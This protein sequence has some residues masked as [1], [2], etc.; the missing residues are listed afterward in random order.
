[1]LRLLRSLS[2]FAPLGLLVVA[3]NYAGD[4]ARLFASGD[5]EAELAEQMLAGRPVVAS[6]R[7]DELRL[8]KRLAERREHAPDV[9]VL[10][11]SRAMPVGSEAFPGRT[12]VNASV[13]SASLEDGIALLELY[14]GLGLKPKLLVLAVE[15]WAL[16]GS[17]RNPSVALEPELRAGLRRLGV[18]AA[19]G[20]GEL[21]VAAAVS[22]KWLKLVSPAY[23]Q[24]SLLA[25]LTRGARAAGPSP[26]S[27][28]GVAAATPGNGHR[29]MPDGSLD[30]G[31]SMAGRTT[32]EAE[33][34]AVATAAG[35]PPYLQAPPAH[36]R[37]VL[38]SA[39]VKSAAERGIR[40]ALWLPPFHPAAYPPLVA[41]RSG[42]VLAEGENAVRALA[43][44]RQVPVLGS[45]DPARSGVT[46]SD[47][48]DYNH[49][50][51][52]AANQLMA[53][54]AGGLSP[55]VRATR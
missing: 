55:D 52:D 36:E 16:N 3:V 46:A 22:R 45:Y 40:V 21:P 20:Y 24:A 49:L 18:H 44:I 43:A 39:L 31:P 15:P 35:N 26:G 9:L 41:G 5:A 25:L 13:S 19:S 30:W 10:G 54:L 7:M 33:A 51:A 32:A 48:V 34:M 27:E 4:P 29:W 42:R 12:V 14:E 17:L 2:R 50:R 38:L 37:L 28:S 1:M 23:F 53:R 6:F 8:Q 11:S 47:F